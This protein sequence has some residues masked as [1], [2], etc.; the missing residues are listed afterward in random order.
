MQPGTDERKHIQPADFAEETQLKA[1]QK[2]NQLRKVRKPKLI[3]E[4]AS[5]YSTGAVSEKQYRQPVKHVK[6]FQATYGLLMSSG[7]KNMMKQTPTT[8]KKS[9][10]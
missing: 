2:N 5:K 10:K 3:P 6:H 1:K 4:K 9:S 8:A 7:D